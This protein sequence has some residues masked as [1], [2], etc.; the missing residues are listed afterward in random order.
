MWRRTPKGCHCPLVPLS[1]CRNGRCSAF[2]GFWFAGAFGLG[3]FVLFQFFWNRTER[4]KRLLI[5]VS[6]LCS[7]SVLST[8]GELSTYRKAWILSG[9]RRSFIKISPWSRCVTGRTVQCFICCCI[10]CL[11]CSAYCEGSN[12]TGSSV[13]SY[14]ILPNLGGIGNY[15][16][17]SDRAYHINALSLTLLFTKMLICGKC[18]HNCVVSTDATI[19]KLKCNIGKK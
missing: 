17:A 3:C 9:I 5:N 10:I 4:N 13:N 19:Y 11:I 15:F 12:V 1:C 14:K 6:F 2:S 16:I 7:N 18:T 8:S